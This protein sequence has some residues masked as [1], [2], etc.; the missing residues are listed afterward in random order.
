MAKELKRKV[1]TEWTERKNQTH[2]MHAQNERGE[3]KR[4]FTRKRGRMKQNKNFF[5]GINEAL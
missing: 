4:V 5:F 3:L 2:N 1:E